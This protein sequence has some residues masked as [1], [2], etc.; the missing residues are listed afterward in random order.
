MVEIDDVTTNQVDEGEEV[1]DVVLKKKVFDQEL[2]NQMIT[3][4]VSALS[5]EA[6]TPFAGD[7]EGRLYLS[8]IQGMR[9]FKPELYVPKEKVEDK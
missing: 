1:Q 6:T 9:N 8:I 7:L 4:W 3:A 2:Y 5:V